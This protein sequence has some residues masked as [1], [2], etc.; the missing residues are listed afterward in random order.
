MRIAVDAQGGKAGPR[1]VLDA[2]VRSARETDVEFLLC[3][4]PD[5][6]R[7]ALDSMGVSPLDPGLRIVDAPDA[8]GLD[9]DPAAARERPLCSAM[10]AARQAALGE[11]D[12]FLSTGNPGAALVASLWH[13]KKL[14]GVLRPAL[15]RTVRTLAGKAVLLDCGASPE[16][17]PWHLMQFALMGC[18]YARALGT[19]SPRVGLL[20]S[21]ARWGPGSES[22][23]ETLALLRH[24]GPEFVGALDGAAFAAGE[25]DVAVCDGLVGGVCA[26]ILEGAA[27]LFAARTA[28]ALQEGMFPVLRRRLL[29]PVLGTASEDFRPGCAPL[30][31]M[32]GVVV[33]SRGDEDARELMEGIRTASLMAGSGL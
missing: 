24:C 32:D 29:D 18:A 22:T 27:A 6:L 26:G 28:A 30:L 13:V 17:K 5:P 12:A 11:A 4:P 20:S 7:R 8:V 21:G 9:E 25:A 15:A 1:P 19:P 14:G 31:G 23:R 16:C 3:G 2:A 10:V 33:L